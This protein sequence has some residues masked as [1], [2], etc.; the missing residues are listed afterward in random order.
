MRE[1]ASA[2]I[3][4]SRLATA[5]RNVEAIL[6]AAE[7]LLQN[8]QEASISAVASEA[9]VSRVTVYSHFA[10][11]R[12]L[13]EALAE[14]AVKRATVALESAEPERGPAVEALQR[15]I[16]AGWA[17]I[18]RHQAIAA[19]AA[20]ELS[21]H[22]MRR[23]H[24]PARMVIGRL[25]ER[26]RAEGAFRTDVSTGWL[27]T[28]CVALMHAAADGVRTGELDANTAVDIL[29]VTIADL[30]VGGQNRGT[31]TPRRA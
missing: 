4:D 1:S 24:E 20:A 3:Q 22:A 23:S 18:G 11:R 12:R 26:G 27:V 2:A 21:G 6:D 15:V 31:P 9:G 17:E 14:R 5:E 28:S 25:V 10:D 8:R 19:A 29:S 13:I 30:L 16:A 7:R